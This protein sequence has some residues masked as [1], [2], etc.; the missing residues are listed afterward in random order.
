MVFHKAQFW[1]HIF[2]QMQQIPPVCR[3]HPALRSRNVAF[4]YLF[5]ECGVL[6]DVFY[7]FTAEVFRIAYTGRAAEVREPAIRLMVVLGHVIIV[8][9]VVL[10]SNRVTLKHRVELGGTFKCWQ[11]VTSP[12]RQRK[13]KKFA[14]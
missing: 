14:F 7:L 6:I 5:T 9:V 10:G 12:E 1:A 4:S 11:T 3:W 13:F 2:L 8:A